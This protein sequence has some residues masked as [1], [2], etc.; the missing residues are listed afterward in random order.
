VRPVAGAIFDPPVSCEVTLALVFVIGCCLVEGGG[1]G[2]R[3]LDTLATDVGFVVVIVCWGTDDDTDDV[4]GGVVVAG[5]VC[6]FTVRGI[7]HIR[8]SVA[9]TTF[10]LGLA[11]SHIFA[12]S[13]GVTESAARDCDDGDCC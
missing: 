12:L 4:C 2:E 1:G 3:G 8:D 5:A 6:G 10:R 11:G 7:P 13:S 9:L